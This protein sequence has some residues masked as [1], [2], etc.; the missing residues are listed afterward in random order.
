MVV[1]LGLGAAAPAV[2]PSLSGLDM[3]EKGQWDLRVREAGGETRK[4]CLGDARQLLQVE[5]H[6]LQCRRFVILDTT[7]QISISYDCGAAGNGRT[8]LR[9]ETPRLVQIQS[10]GIT[11]GAPF[12]YAI[13]GRRVGVCH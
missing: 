13:E 5:H 2:A 12:S 4:L 11:N 8:D 1:A 9:I 7:R 10:Q 3:L 6:G